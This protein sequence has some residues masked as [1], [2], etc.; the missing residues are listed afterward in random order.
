[1]KENEEERDTYCVA[2][3][4]T[5]EGI[6]GKPGA[7]RKC[8][9]QLECLIDRL[10]NEEPASDDLESE[11]EMEC[12]ASE[13]C[14]SVMTSKLTGREE[15]ESEREGSGC[16]VNQDGLKSMK[17]G[18]MD[19]GPIGT[20]V[21]QIMDSRQ[22]WRGSFLNKNN[23]FFSVDG[24]EWTDESYTKQGEMKIGCTVSR[25]KW[26]HSAEQHE[27]EERLD[28]DVCGD[29]VFEDNPGSVGSPA[30]SILTSGY[31]TCRL[32]SLKD[33][34]DCLDCRGDCTL[35]LHSDSERPNDIYW[36]DDSGLS[37]YQGSLALQASGQ[38]IPSL[39][40]KGSDQSLFDHCGRSEGAS[41]Q[42]CV[43][44]PLGELDESTPDEQTT[45]V[46]GE[47]DTQPSATKS[48]DCPTREQKCT[49]DVRYQ[50]TRAASH[51]AANSSDVLEAGTIHL[52]YQH[53]FNMRPDK[54]KTM[55]KDRRY[56]DGYQRQETRKGM[57]VKAHIFTLAP[58]SELE[59]CLDRLRVSA[60]Q[61]RRDLDSVSE[62]RGSCAD[63]QSS[64]T[65][66]LPSAFQ[67][68]IKSMTRSRSESDIRP[69]PKSFIRPVM[70]H[71]HT[72]NLKK[73]DPVAKY[74]QYKQDWELFKAPGE[75]S[76]K[77]LHWAIREQLM[78]QPPPPKP[79]RTYIPNNY[80]V[81][82]A[83]KRS[84]L[85]WEIRHDLANG[86]IPTKITYP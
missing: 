49:T 46:Y 77:E 51:N 10:K 16:F 63:T 9:S 83:K 64:A 30:A 86:I 4:N 14:K 70:D 2:V 27:G 32:D 48:I 68:Y 54:G 59:E 7:G 81:P 19:Y 26:E 36:E 42:H 74:F 53:P 47:K 50:V 44:Q 40:V 35:T 37:W 11:R 84:A 61:G 15:Q 28:E 80:V 23:T 21:K 66:E 76:R 20:S 55:T 3:D 69:R 24:K 33:D 65:E 41:V 85:R 72:R 79:Q 18:R 71:P 67:A 75:R 82:T 62:E 17:K 38:Q 5:T 45:N 43:G 78:Y 34:L 8:S 73:N 1:M 52:D 31:G 29:K 60:P 56:K 6:G 39:S 25:Q 13:A 58:V 12:F 57:K 22:E